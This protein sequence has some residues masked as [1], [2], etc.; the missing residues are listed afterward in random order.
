MRRV[1]VTGASS[2]IGEAV[3]EGLAGAGWQVH[4]LARRAARLEALAARCGCAAHAGDVRD[5]AAME[6]LV[7]EVAPDALVLNAGRGAGFEGLAR[8]SR[9]ALAETIETNVTAVLDLIR[10]A[11][12]GMIRR[13]RGHV[14]V[15]GSVAALYPA[16]AA[17]YGGS[18]AAVAMIARNLRLELRGTGV[19]VTDVRPGRVTTEFYDVAMADAAAA[20]R[21]KDTGI[22]ELRPEDVAEAVRW[23]LAAPAHVNVS[24]VELQPVEQTYGGAFF[25]PVGEA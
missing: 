22:R 3:A 19:R 18:K 7:A 4:A 17:V 15:V 9:E 11:L 10:L 12:P 20:A 6:A 25:D 14:V 16:P 2:G 23:A 5:G 13:R 1:L 8:A 24:A 21:A